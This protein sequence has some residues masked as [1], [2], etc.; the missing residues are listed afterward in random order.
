MSNAI[1]QQLLTSTGDETEE[2][3]QILSLF[4]QY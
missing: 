1:H 2:S 4:I 3:C